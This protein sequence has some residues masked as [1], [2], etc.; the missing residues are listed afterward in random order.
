MSVTAHVSVSYNVPYSRENV[1]AIAV[2]FA[3][4]VR[5]NWALISEVQHVEPGL[6]CLPPN[7]ERWDTEA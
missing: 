1:R 2:A 4:A 7:P 6:H 5:E 3:Q